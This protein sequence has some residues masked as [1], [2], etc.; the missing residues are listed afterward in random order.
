MKYEIQ[1]MEATI[2]EDNM[3]DIR[4]ILYGEPYDV[5]S[6]VEGGELIDDEGVAFEEFKKCRATARKKEDG[7]IKIRI[8]ELIRGEEE[9][10]GDISDESGDEIYLISEYEAIARAEFDEE[11][12]ELFRELGYADIGA[13]NGV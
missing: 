1:T 7:S 12:L 4:E 5:I 9:L 11:A 10:D 2:T 8:P 3:S 13:K 6:V